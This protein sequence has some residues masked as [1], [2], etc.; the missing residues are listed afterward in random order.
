MNTLR[1]IALLLLAHPVDAQVY[2]VRAI[3]HTP[4]YERI[5]HAK[6]GVDDLGPLARYPETNRIDRLFTESG[7]ERTNGLYV[8]CLSEV[9][10]SGVALRAPGS[11]ISLENVREVLRYTVAVPRSSLTNHLGHAGGGRYVVTDMA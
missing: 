8:S 9:P 7:R 11:L 1:V 4:H 10:L 3:G 6:G 2:C 5:F